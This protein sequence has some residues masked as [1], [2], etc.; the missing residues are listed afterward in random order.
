MAP[1]ANTEAFRQ[2]LYLHS[3]RYVTAGRYRGRVRV[4]RSLAWRPYER[5][6]L[7]EKAVVALAVGLV[8]DVTTLDLDPAYRNIVRVDDE[9]GVDNRTSSN[10]AP[11]C[12]TRKVLV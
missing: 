8:E 12:D 2:S 9:V 10:T 11:R 4:S 3:T 6:V 5:Y 7:K 1:S